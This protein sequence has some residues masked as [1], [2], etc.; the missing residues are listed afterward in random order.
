M[1]ETGAFCPQGRFDVTQLVG[2]AQDFVD[3]DRLSGRYLL[4]EA[5]VFQEQLTTQAV[6]QID[7]R[8]QISHQALRQAACGVAQIRIGQGLLHAGDAGAQDAVGF[9]GVDLQQEA[10][11][12]FVGQ[13][14]NT[15]QLCR[16]DAE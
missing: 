7:F 12:L 11:G 16:I 4:V 9:A 6:V 5:D 15:L 1:Q 13:E 3:I 10:L 2:Q 14:R 8:L